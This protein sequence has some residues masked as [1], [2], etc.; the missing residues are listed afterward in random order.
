MRRAKRQHKIS[1]SPRRIGGSGGKTVKGKG[2]QTFG[3]SSS[4]QGNTP[5]TA[6]RRPRKQDG[7][8]PKCG[9]ESRTAAIKPT[10]KRK[11]AGALS[12]FTPTS[13]PPA[14]EPPIH[15]PP[16]CD[17]CGG[18]ARPRIRY[19]GRHTFCLLCSKCC[20]I[21]VAVRAAEV[22]ELNLLDK[23]RKSK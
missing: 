14:L 19:R 22:K 16:K 2:K 5:T 18:I 10:S 21:T 12:P 17:R 7:S 23:K 11:K 3:G 1:N 13:V 4:N 20:L 8:N 9:C 6:I 15:P